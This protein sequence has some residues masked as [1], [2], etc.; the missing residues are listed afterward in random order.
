MCARAEEMPRAV[1]TT[2]WGLLKQ[3]NILGADLL[4]DRGA[5]P[6]QQGPTCEVGCWLSS[7]RRCPAPWNPSWPPLIEHGVEG[8]IGCELPVH[9]PGQ[10]QQLLLELVLQ[11]RQLGTGHCWSDGLQ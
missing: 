10:K 2:F 4:W 8:H 3:R 5:W 11:H 7:M 9:W 1:K 6:V